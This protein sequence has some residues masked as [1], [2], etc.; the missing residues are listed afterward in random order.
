MINWAGNGKRN[1][2]RVRPVTTT[3]EIEFIKADAA[4]CR[5]ALAQEKG[6]RVR[7]G[8]EQMRDACEVGAARLTYGACRRVR[9]LERMPTARHG[10]GARAH[11][12][13]KDQYS[14]DARKICLNIAANV[15][16]DIVS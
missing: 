5:L 8:D 7:G 12:R 3:L 2:W 11:A 9:K 13:S 15:R 6:E 10:L 4:K 16:G 14:A 1:S